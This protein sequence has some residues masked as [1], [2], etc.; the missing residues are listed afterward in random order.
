MMIKKM[1]MSGVGMLLMLSTAVSAHTSRA[2]T[3]LANSRGNAPASSP[4][5][6]A[7][8]ANLNA[9]T[10]TANELLKLSADDAQKRCYEYMHDDATEYSSC[11][12][13]V[14][15][16]VK[17]KDKNTQLQRLGIVYFAWVGANNSA[18]MSLPGS[19]A[20]AQFYLPKFRKIQKQLKISDEE[21]CPA[22]AGECKARVAQI[23]QM[24]KELSERQAEQR[25]SKI[26]KP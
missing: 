4:A 24:E 12:N 13:A 17:G 20:A 8:N 10:L 21:L 25:K 23:L 26:A 9:S 22:I 2:A 6:L 5:S 16:A 19:E 14:L 3:E 11:L 1:M 18:R 7:A 15:A